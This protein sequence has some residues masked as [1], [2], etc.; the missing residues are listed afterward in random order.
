[1]ADLNNHALFVG[2]EPALGAWAEDGDGYGYTSFLPNSLHGVRD[3]G[4][5]WVRWGQMRA[6]NAR[7]HAAYCHRVLARP[8]DQ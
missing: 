4:P 8:A 5:Y 7:D 6:L 3:I 2:W 1:V